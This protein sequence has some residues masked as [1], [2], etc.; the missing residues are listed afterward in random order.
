MKQ[1]YRISIIA[2]LSL[3]PILLYGQGNN[4]YEN[5]EIKVINQ[6]LY[7]LIDAERLSKYNETDKPLTLYFHTGLD[8][9]LNKSHKKEYKRNI[10]LKQLDNSNLG[11]RFIDSTKIEKLKNVDIIFGR[12]N[13]YPKEKYNSK[14]VIG[15]ISFSRT[16]F[17]K[18]LTT[19][20]FYYDVY[21]GEDC[22]HG[23]LIR[24]KKNNG[25]WIIDDYISMW[26]S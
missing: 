21:C 17:N 2:I 22:G 6:F 14:R 8:C 18:S 7:K 13:M 10:L 16:S 24:I 5:E 20:Y 11:R 12:K 3:A 26:I 15:T 4:K 25:A 23:A 19:G 1:L 9:D